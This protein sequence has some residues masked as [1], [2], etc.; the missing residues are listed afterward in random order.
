[1]HSE[2]TFYRLLGVGL[3]NVRHDEAAAHPMRLRSRQLAPLCTSASL[4]LV[5]GQGACIA[6]PEREP[7]FTDQ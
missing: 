4:W 7:A 6:E 1:M 5:R 2:L 3:A